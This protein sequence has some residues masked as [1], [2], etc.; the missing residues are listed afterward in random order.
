[1]RLDNLQHQISRRVRTH[2]L[3]VAWGT[4]REEHTNA[5][6]WRSLQFSASRRLRR[7]R[8]AAVLEWWRDVTCRCKKLANQLVRRHTNGV[9]KAVQGAIRDWRE[10]SVYSRRI[11]RIGSRILAARQYGVCVEVRGV[12]H[13]SVIRARLRA[14]AFVHHAR[15]LVM[16]ILRAWKKQRADQQ[17]TLRIHH[18]VCTKRHKCQQERVF[19]LWYRQLI[20]QAIF[21]RLMRRCVW[22]CHELVVSRAWHTWCHYVRCQLRRCLQPMCKDNPVGADA[23]GRPLISAIATPFFRERVWLVHE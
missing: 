21:A 22:R 19:E 3:G 15:R 16:K 17:Y 10:Y 13:W 9:K 18:R 20:R 6:T 2:S 8:I 5:M 4:W 1:M 23:T 7:V 11:K 14:T 12:W